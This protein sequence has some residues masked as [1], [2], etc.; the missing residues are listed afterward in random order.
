V[1]SGDEKHTDVEHNLNPTM[2]LGYWKWALQT[3]QQ[4][5]VRLGMPPDPRYDDVIKHL[6][7][8]IVRAGVYPA[9]EIPVET[10]PAFMATWLFGALPGN[11]I[12]KEA[13]RATLHATYKIDVPQNAVTWGTAMAAMCAARLNEPDRAIQMLVGQYDSNPFRA[14]GYSVRRPEQTPMYMPA[15][16]G[17]L[18]ATA[19]M[20]AGWDGNTQHAP[21]FP[22]NWK[23]RYEGLLPLP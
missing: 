6:A 1:S 12:D 2:E 16:G 7:T 19:M 15:N 11:G 14:S 17:W 23:V 20:A 4:W 9:L 5:R 8:P 21:G 22:K 18:T 3:A 10:K 13:L